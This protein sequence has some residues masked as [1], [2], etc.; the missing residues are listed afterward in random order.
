[1][2]TTIGTQDRSCIHTYIQPGN[3]VVKRAPG[4][5]GSIHN[6]L[7]RVICTSRRDELHSN[8]T[9]VIVTRPSHPLV[10]APALA[11]LDS[12]RRALIDARIVAGKKKKEK[13]MED[14][15]IV[16]LVPFR[17]EPSAE[18]EILTT[19]GSLVST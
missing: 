1:M 18:V 7:Y 12:L 6:V 17:S 3:P 9:R 16:K 11:H 19:L 5:L 2:T 15:V 14:S 13:K 8:D 4:S 10:P